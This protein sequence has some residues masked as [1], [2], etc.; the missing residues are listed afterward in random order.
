MATASVVVVVVV[1]VECS[2]F[3]MDQIILEVKCEIVMS[4]YSP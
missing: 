1:V 3:K 2:A 4:S